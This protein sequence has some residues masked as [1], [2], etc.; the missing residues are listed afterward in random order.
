MLPEAA[1]S[2]TDFQKA[3]VYIFTLQ[4]TAFFT[5][6]QLKWATISQKMKVFAN[7]LWPNGS[8]KDEFWEIFLESQNRHFTL[9][10][11][12]SCSVIAES[13]P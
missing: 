9:Q 7:L 4:K 13:S 2:C 10:R 8:S 1:K 6:N 3:E 5:K 11:R 12:K